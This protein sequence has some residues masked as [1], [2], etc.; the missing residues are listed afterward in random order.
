M[1]NK[2]KTNNNAPK[3]NEVDCKESNP[4]NNTQKPNP[5]NIK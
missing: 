3:N 5:S 4:S 1:D 2:N